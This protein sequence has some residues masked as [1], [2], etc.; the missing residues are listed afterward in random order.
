MVKFNILL[1]LLGISSLIVGGNASDCDD[2]KNSFKNDEINFID[3]CADNDNGQ[4]VII[5]FRGETVTQEAINKIASYNTLEQLYFNRVRSFPEDLNLSSLSLDVVEF[6]DLNGYKNRGFNEH[7]T[8]KNV[9]KTLK[10]VKKI[11]ISGYIISQNTLDE[12]G[13]LTKVTAIELYLN[14]FEEGLDFSKFKNNK[15]LTYLLCTKFYNENGLAKIPSSLCQLK[16]LKK[17]DLSSNGISTVPKCLGNLENLE[18]LNLGYNTIKSFPTEFGKLTKLRI[19]EVAYNEMT[20]IPSAFGKFTKLENLVA[21]NNKIKKFSSALCKLKNVKNL[22]LSSNEISS[23]PSCIKN[24]KELVSIDLGIN[25]ISKLPDEIFGLANLETLDLYNNVFTK[26]PSNAKNNKKLYYLEMSY[27]KITKIP[28]SIKNLKK[29]KILNLNYNEITNLPSALGELKDLN[30]LTLSSNKID[31]EIPESLNNLTN[32]QYLDLGDNIDI[33][34]KTLTIE[35]ILDCD[36]NLS[37]N[38]SNN[39][40]AAGSLKCSFDKTEIPKCEN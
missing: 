21:D 30:S 4:V 16:Q 40:C 25:Q 20:S 32:L 8:P 10:K 7:N 12:L 11:I 17:L 2:I 31:A 1:I 5:H 34:G 39:L 6:Y 35:G 23:V 27:N 15:N 18:Q 3:Y 24:L 26:F 13:S 9:L 14:R 37:Y 38:A 36:Y 29:L 22:R 19:L 28:S 33:R